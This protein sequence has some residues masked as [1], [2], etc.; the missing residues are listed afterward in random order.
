MSAA[1]I[2][3]Q[4]R[5]SSKRFPGK[6]LTDLHGEPMLIRLLERLDLVPGTQVLIAT[7]DQPSDDAIAEVLA[8]AGRAC[9]RG[10]LDDVLARYVGAARMADADPIVRITA[11]C[12]L[13]D[14]K[15]IESMLGRF[16]DA[17]GG[18]D[19]L[20]NVRPP[21]FPDGLDIEIVSRDALERAAEECQDAGHREHV[22]LHLHEHPERF[23]HVLFA[24]ANDRSAERWT[25]DYPADLEFVRSVYAALYPRFGPR[26]G[27]AEIDAL[28][29]RAPIE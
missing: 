25:V 20:S 18:A 21:T 16:Q 12:P 26:F 13:A 14:P 28:L 27:I 19:I 6:V 24:A 2:V 22:L 7:S 11:D 23:H 4:A 1:T 5:M 17:G 15:L 10:P 29:T 3:V 9:Y 8:V